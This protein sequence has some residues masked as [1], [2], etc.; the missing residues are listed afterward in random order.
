MSKRPA[1]IAT[2]CAAAIAVIGLVALWRKP[3]PTTTARAGYAASP[4]SVGAG[5]LASP[6]SAGVD[7]L[8]VRRRSAQVVEPVAGETGSAALADTA[9]AT[10]TAAQRAAARAHPVPIPSVFGG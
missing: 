7:P 2:I 5:R 4:A 9:P 10:P 6:A 3:R 8:P 1:V